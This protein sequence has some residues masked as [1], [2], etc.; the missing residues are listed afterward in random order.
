MKRCMRADPNDCSDAELIKQE[1][2]RPPS[3]PVRAAR[4]PG[5]HLESP[6]ARVGRERPDRGDLRAGVAA[7]A[8]LS[9]RA[10]RICPSWAA[11]NRP[12]H[13]PGDGSPRSCRDTRPRAPWAA[14]GRRPARGP[15]GRLQPAAGSASPE[16]NDHLHGRRRS[17]V[18]AGRAGGH[19]V[20]T[21]GVHDHRRHRP[22]RCGLRRKAV[23]AIAV[24]R[25]L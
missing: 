24:K 7:T 21:A 14:S 20:R 10:R 8:P 4:A 12:K 5:L 15:A 18:R 11:R 1:Q 25:W 3:V 16:G 13:P 2:T 6:P 22:V 9:R 19:A 23:F 17:T